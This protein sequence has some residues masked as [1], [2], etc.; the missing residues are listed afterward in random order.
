M[1]TPRSK[2]CE[3]C[4]GCSLQ[5]AGSDFLQPEGQGTLRVAILGEASGE[6]EARDQLPFRPYAASGSVLE[7]TIRRIGLAREQF[8]IANTIFC[9]PFGNALDGAGYEHDA[10]SHC[11]PNVLGF[12]RKFKP[13]V[14]LTLG[15]VSTRTMTGLAGEHRGV[16]HLR[17]YVLRALPQFETAA[18]RDH[19]SDPLL[20]IPS[21]HPAFLRRGAIHLTGV[22]ARD[23]ARA[24][25]VAAGRDKNFILDLPDLTGYKDDQLGSWTEE[26]DREN[27]ASV[28]EA[29]AA[30]LTR[31]SLRYQLHPTRRELDWFCR[32]VKARSDGWMAKS[33]DERENSH[34]YLSFDLETAESASLDEDATDGF[35]D[36]II[37]LIQFS[38][39]PG[40][41]IAMDWQGE[42]IQAA[43]W[44][45][46]LPLGK[47]TFNG[48][49][50]DNKVLR[51]VGERDFGNRDYL[52]PAG[53]T[54]DALQQFHF[55]QSDLPAHL[56]F[57]SSFS[58]FPFPWKHYNDSCLEFYG[59]CDPDAAGRV[60]LTTRKTMEDRKIWWDS[61]CPA[62]QAA[63]Y[64]A[65]VEMVR[66]IL[67]AMEDRG[68]PVDDA[69]RLALGV[70]FDAAE[71]EARAELD[72][73]FPDEA[74]KLTPKNGYKTVPAHVKEILEGI[75]AT[76][77]PPEDAV[78]ENGKKLTKIARAKLE[79]EA[80]DRRYNNVTEEEMKVVRTTRFQ[81][82]PTKNDEG[83]EEEG[84][85]YFY[86]IRHFA[87]TDLQWCRVYEFSPNSS[88]QLMAYMTHHRHKIPQS[89]D[90]KNTTGKKELI[91]L[92]ARQKDTFYT[93][94][95]ECREIR[96]MKTTYIDG[97]RPHADGCVHTTFTFATAIGQLSSRNPNCFSAD[98][99]VLTRRGWVLFPDLQPDDLVAEW[100]WS[101]V[102][103]QVRF[104]RPIS[105]IREP[106]DGILKYIHTDEQLDMCMT[107]DHN[108]LLATRRS[109][110]LKR[111][112][113]EDYPPD[114]RQIQAGFYEGGNVSLS[115]AQVALI[116]AL[117][118]D[119]HVMKG[120]VDTKGRRRGIGGHYTFTFKKKRKIERFLWA[121][122]ECEIV[123]SRG[124]GGSGH[125]SFYV[126]RKDIPSWWQDRK[127]FDDW[128]LEF[129]RAT[130]DFMAQEIYLWDGTLR[131]DSGANYSSS[132]KPNTDWAQIITILS[133]RRAK[134]RLYP[135]AGNRK[136]NWQTDVAGNAHSMTTNA[137][138]DDVPYQGWVHCVEMPWGTVIVRRNGKVA[139]TGNCQN[140]PKHGRLAKAIRQMIAAKPGKLLA[141]WDFKS[142]HVLT[143][144][145]LANDPNYIRL[146]RID[147]HSIMTGHF[148]KLWRV[149]DILRETD[150]ELKE[151][152]RWLKS[153]EKYKEMRDSKIK[154]AGLGIGN[155]LRANGLY[156]RY[157]EFFSGV[158]EAK[159]ILA[160][161]EEV[162]PKVFA[163]QKRTQQ[164][165]HEQTF[166]QSE[167][168][169]ARYYYEVFRWDSRAGT[170][171]HGDQ[172]EEAISFWLSNI[173]FGHIREKMKELEKLGMAA[174][175]G[176]CDNIHDSFLF[177]FD[178]RL[179]NEML[180][181]VRPVLESPS[182]VLV[183]PAAP[184]GL[185]IGVDCAVGKNW[186]EMEEVKSALK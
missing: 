131:S 67:A 146:A 160:A 186:A 20:V 158:A 7:R 132:V 59:C 56:Q 153:N 87:E 142:C 155:G 97:F 90:G 41:A 106:F 31:H 6:N 120:V 3:T 8:A 82:P 71:K 36:T 52:T 157:M 34:L 175:Y 179:L 145:Y 21:Y 159:A 27:A 15:N 74:R 181:E 46:K 154:H 178:E 137:I 57:A 148:L 26:K 144:G 4:Q 60:Y 121:L 96:K 161:Y 163:W 170:W 30:W 68:L 126:S 109:G 54:H 55:F 169:Y 124:R 51:A 38:I 139:F 118:A 166:L 117:Q 79:K 182:K 48:W 53:T 107:P 65:Q 103:T 92:A 162:F 123:F 185:W 125:A 156:E 25:N 149:Q 136:D 50:F 69:R 104:S 64:V 135:G 86:D 47:V 61:A 81:D 114:H 172:G 100:A 173:A 105:F 184:D 102:A 73:R 143:L 83:E 39:E 85:R 76:G 129:D 119:G 183:G 122:A 19:S 99:E 78:G 130:L 91:R 151:R 167:F 23:I 49:L 84:E 93:K 77:L 110:R 70:E 33:P 147:M 10:I 138:I 44:L 141:E 176:L 113:A 29:L 37:R 66:P 95:I 133:G 11:E 72:S 13:K 58:S 24:V 168:G 115:E 134:V 45:L 80:R 43:R 180:L 75:Q 150:A 94:V 28:R 16:G 165:A 9:R 12:L 152:C 111:F 140:F 116:C 2:S 1:M 108:C 164:L 32:D 128:I 127:F 112:A 22:L 62:R 171:G 101:E 35:T 177:H 18:G 88:P 40:Q 174:K 42:H 14:V 5:S 89:K 98:T 63:G 17:G